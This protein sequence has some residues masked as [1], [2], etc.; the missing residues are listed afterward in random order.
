MSEKI[1]SDSR[2]F[3][4]VRCVRFLLE[5]G[6]GEFVLLDPA[7]I[8]IMRDMPVRPE[9]ATILGKPRCVSLSLRCN[10]QDSSRYLS[11]YVM[12]SIEEILAMIELAS[13]SC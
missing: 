2:R 7:S 11:V 5:P 9:V 6:Y 8:G 1:L 4:R 12:E 3:I 10:R 13:E